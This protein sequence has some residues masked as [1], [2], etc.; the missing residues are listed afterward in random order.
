[1][2]FDLQGF[3]PPRDP[4]ASP[5][6]ILPCRLNVNSA[7]RYDF[8]GFIPLKSVISRAETQQTSALLA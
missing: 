6:Q 1:M 2:R 8:E 3:S 4:A 7:T 5:Q